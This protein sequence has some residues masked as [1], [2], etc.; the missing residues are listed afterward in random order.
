[1]YLIKGQIDLL[2]NRQL[3]QQLLR[4]QH[5]SKPALRTDDKLQFQS[6]HRLCLSTNSVHFANILQLK[7]VPIPY[8]SRLSNCLVTQSDH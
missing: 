6:S 2:S 5:I 7:L 8:Q 3:L 1:M 4:G